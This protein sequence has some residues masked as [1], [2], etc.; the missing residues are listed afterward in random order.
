MSTLSTYLG[1][2]SR[3]LA[4]SSENYF[5]ADERKAAVNWAIQDF[6]DS[7]KPPELKLKATLTT[8]S[9]ADSDYLI[10]DLPTGVQSERQISRIWVP[11]SKQTF[12]YKDPDNYLNLVSDNIYTIDYNETAAARKIHIGVETI[13]GTVKINYY[14]NPA[15]LVND[16]DESGISSRADEL[17]VYIAAEKMLSDARDF[18]AMAGVGALKRKAVNTWQGKHGREV[19]RIR[20]RFEREDYLTRKN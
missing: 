18:E 20:S 10:A 17:I 8:A 3:P 4:T 14:I 13:V 16:V 5:D 6:V 12:I 9:D 7:Y 2:L 1:L 11:T 19:K 15:T